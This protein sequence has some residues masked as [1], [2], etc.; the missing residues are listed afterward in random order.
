MQEAEEPKLVHKRSQ[1][2]A[3]KHEFAKKV[4]H[5]LNK[6]GLIKMNTNVGAFESVPQSELSP[7]KMN[8]F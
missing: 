7:I 1:A 4:N 3:R 2:A 5:T 6:L 8:R